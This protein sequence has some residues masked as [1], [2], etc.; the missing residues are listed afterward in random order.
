MIHEARYDIRGLRFPKAGLLIGDVQHEYL[1]HRYNP[2]AGQ[3]TA[4]V[5]RHA[6]TR[7]T[8]TY[9]R[10]TQKGFNKIIRPFGNLRIKN[11]KMYDE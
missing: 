6:S 3:V 2:W 1:R 11:R 4:E 10:L 5:V 7:T 9:V 8:E